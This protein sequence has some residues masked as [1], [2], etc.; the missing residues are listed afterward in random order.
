M[1][2]PSLPTTTTSFAEELPASPEWTKYVR[3]R[4]V[5]SLTDIIRRW[6]HVEIAFADDTGYVRAYAGGKIFD[7][8]NA[9]CRMVLQTREGFR[10]C[11]GS[12]R[13][14]FQLVSNI[15]KPGT[16]APS[17][18]FAENRCHMGFRKI[19]VPVE[20]DGRVIGSVIAGGILPAGEPEKL[21]AD[22][23][24][25]GT[26]YGVDA[27]MIHAEFSALPRVDEMSLQYL[28][29]LIASVVREVAMYHR[30]L[31]EKDRSIAKLTEELHGK[32]AFGA[33]I[34]A[35]R[36]MRDMLSMLEKVCNSDSTVLVQGE[37]GTG[38]ELVARAV[39]V[40]SS[41]SNKPFLMQ[42]AAAFNENLLE[43][44]LFGHMRG[45]FTGAI[46]DKRG[47]FEVADG[48]TFFLDEVGE[49]SAA[50]QVKLLRV[51][52]EGTFMPVGSTEPKKVDVRLVCATNR[53]L[54][55]MV[56]R[57]E[58]REDLYYRINV[59]N[60]VIPPLRDRRDDVPLLVKHFLKRFAEERKSGVKEVTEEVLER[61]YDYEWPGNIRE[62]ENEIE[63][64][65]V[66]SGDDQIVT[67]EH[68]SARIKEKSMRANVKGV[69]VD[70]GLDEILEEVERR[71]LSEG[72]RKTRW[73]K[74]QLARQLGISRKGLIAKVQRYQLD[75][76]KEDR[77]R[78]ETRR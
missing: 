49:M 34:G 14:T 27:A 39:H 75:R 15:R 6:F 41:R 11:I 16:K 54:R 68:L 71:V 3:L 56:E 30:E 40:N 22:L 45:S 21:L 9:V 2:S 47:L 60:V 55:R 61:F 36:P 48:G 20:V 62:L 19:V 64:L 7:P 12:S 67:T 72:L 25:R 1:I 42:S 5:K 52:Q 59:I 28:C 58:F 57:G 65:V 24:T 18:N 76:R 53:D 66:L 29:E 43:S 33:I 4:A 8:T 73:N 32:Y 44:E 74:T 63:R 13:E 46:K 31:L 38:K 50:L 23:I 37:N 77:A 51:L 35:S 10:G 26:R 78:V 17:Q 69:R 70:K